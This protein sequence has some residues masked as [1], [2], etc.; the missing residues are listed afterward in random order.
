[1]PPYHLLTLD[2]YT[3]LFDLETSL[4]PDLARAAKVDLDAARRLVSAWHTHQQTYYLLSNSLGQGRV[5]SR[6]VLRRALD[7]TLG[8][9]NLACAETERDLLVAAWDALVPW[10]ETA[11]VLTTLH[12]RGYPLALLSNGDESSLRALAG[13]LP[14]PMAGIYAGDQAGV[15][16]P[17]PALYALPLQALSLSP[18]EVLHI[19]GSVGDTLGARAAGLPCYWSNRRGKHLYDPALRPTYEY[20]DLRGLLDV[21]PAPVESALNDVAQG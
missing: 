5:L 20:P 18:D 15:Y 1:V 19:S 9:A 3:A 7:V 8:E 13:R 14:V 17:H 11:A 21:L 4:G 10:T 16:K 2:V 12:R 6:T